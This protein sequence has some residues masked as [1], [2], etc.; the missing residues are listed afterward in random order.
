MV[1]VLWGLG[2]YH[3]H[4]AELYQT[5]RIADEMLELGESLGDDRGAGCAFQLSVADFPQLHS[6]GKKWIDVES[7]N[8][9]RFRKSGFHK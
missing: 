5:I 6:F 9:L 2:P 4:R 1:P 8:Q 3:L 7:A